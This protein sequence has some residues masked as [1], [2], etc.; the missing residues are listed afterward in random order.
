MHWLIVLQYNN[1]LFCTGVVLQ[2]I[3][4]LS[5]V[6]NDPLGMMLYLHVDIQEVDLQGQELRLVKLAVQKAS[7]F[8]PRFIIIAKRALSALLQ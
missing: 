6:I 4:S 3:I 5:C 2:N 1:R 8:M 7:L